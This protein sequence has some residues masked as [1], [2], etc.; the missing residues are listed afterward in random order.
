M[1]HEAMKV[2]IQELGPKGGWVGKIWSP[3]WVIKWLLSPESDK[4]QMDLVSN[5]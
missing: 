1:D 5:S 3:Q 2:F 4:Q